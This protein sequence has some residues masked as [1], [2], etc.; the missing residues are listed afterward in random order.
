[1][2]LP[3][4]IPEKP[5]EDYDLLPESEISCYP[6]T[7]SKELAMGEHLIPSIASELREKGNSAELVR[8]RHTVH[9]RKIRPRALASTTGLHTGSRASPEADRACHSPELSWAVGQA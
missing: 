3:Q 2:G 7:T 8:R 6:L 5:V 4:P 1:M 9:K